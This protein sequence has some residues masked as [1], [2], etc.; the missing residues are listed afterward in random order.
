MS[1]ESSKPTSASGVSL[2]ALNMGLP[3]N[4][5]VVNSKPTDKIVSAL[6]SSDCQLLWVRG[7][8]GVGR[9][10]LVYDSI[11][12]LS[13]RTDGFL[14]ALRVE[15]WPG[16]RIEQVLWSIGE[17]LK[18]LG[19][20]LLYRVLHE[21]TTL[22]TK[23]RL[24]LQIVRDHRV[25][26]WLDD[27]ENIEVPESDSNGNVLGT[28]LE[29]IGELGDFQGRLVVVTEKNGP[30]RLRAEDT[31][32][33]V[34]DVH[35]GDALDC[36]ELWGVLKTNLD[37]ELPDSTRALAFD[38]IPEDIRNNPLALR[39]YLHYSIPENSD[40]SVDTMETAT[41]LNSLATKIRDELDTGAQRMLDLLALYI[42]PISRGTLWAITKN[43]KEIQDG[44]ASLEAL[45]RVGIVQSNRTDNRIHVHSALRKMA[46]RRS[47]AENR[48]EWL[49]HHQAIADHYA[50]TASRASSIW[51]HYSAFRHWARCGE[52][53]KAYETQK[54]FIEFFMGSGY[55]DLARNVLEFLLDRIGSP[56]R[57]V[58]IGNLAIIL[59]KTG[60]HRK[61]IEL[62]ERSLRAFVNRGDMVNASR[63]YHQI[64]NT[65]YAE[66]DH[67]RALENYR[68][69][70]E[71]AKEVKDP[72]V[73]LMASVQIGNVYFSSDDHTTALQIYR[74][75]LDA[76]EEV[77]HRKI[78][79]ALH[80]QIAQI[81][82]A[83]NQLTD[84]ETSLTTAENIATEDENL[85][86]VLKIL[87]IRSVVANEA[88]NAEDAL[89]HLERAG[90]IASSLGDPV[91]HA[92]CLLQEGDIEEKRQRFGDAVKRFLDARCVITS[93]LNTSS[94]Q[95]EKAVFRSALQSID[96]RILA[97][98]E[99]LGDAAFGRILRRDPKIE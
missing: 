39:L 4:E 61:A 93:T 89:S 50:S 44:E 69:S 45:R 20:E 35:P 83:Q 87:Q 19:I 6:E 15:C 18:Q 49:K 17:F 79:A 64:G 10:T 51:H 96:D 58:V 68:Q 57:E 27:F 43:V 59:K 60:E 9:S 52:E 55:L 80:T 34:F 25:W 1:E 12:R 88:H 32:A 3:A 47:H 77:N 76:A 72:V 36:K 82:L 78:I 21:Q 56:F 70:F 16:L 13:G 98:K 65:Y 26:I 67:Q 90:A 63:V 85:R 14:G 8:G 54:S 86:Q 91:E 53:E 29:T 11:E 62:Y 42:R 97:L 99:S 95:E 73:C 7:P 5:L 71:I 92:N 2:L 31:P 94:E 33:V 38:E 74:E 23:M 84:S 24:L 37:E 81:H 46:A 75:A 66:G 22:A 48:D 30:D 28:F 40:T 41:N